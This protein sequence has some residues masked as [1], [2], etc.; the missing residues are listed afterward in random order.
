MLRFVL[1]QNLSKPNPFGTEEF[2]QFR[3]VL[4]VHRIKLHRH[5][6]DGTVKSVWLKQ[7]FGLL[8][9]RF[10]QVSLLYISVC[11]TAILYVIV[12][13]QRL[14]KCDALINYLFWRQL[15]QSEIAPDIYA[16]HILFSVFIE[17]KWIVVNVSQ[18]NE[19]VKMYKYYIGAFPIQNYCVRHAEKTIKFLRQQNGTVWFP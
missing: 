3:Q 6:V 14:F 9:V 4:G 12:T 17:Q 8:R 18:V 16:I 11:I 5:L 2:V 7:V 19:C 15:S 10:R 13:Y 1:Q